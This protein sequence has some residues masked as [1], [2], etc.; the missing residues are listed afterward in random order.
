MFDGIIGM[1]FPENAVFYEFGTGV[2]T[3]KSDVWSQRIQKDWDTAN[4]LMVENKE[5]DQFQ[6]EVITAWKYKKN[7]SKW[8]R[9]KIKGWLKSYLRRRLK[10]RKTEILCK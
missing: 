7:K 8:H 3:K 4:L 5:L 1:Y 10:T 9:L 6:E 2:S